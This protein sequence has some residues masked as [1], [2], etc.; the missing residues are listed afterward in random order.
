M[1]RAFRLVR[2]RH[3]PEARTESASRG[4]GAMLGGAPLGPLAQLAEQWTFNPLV[5][6]S[7]PTRSTRI[8]PRSGTS[9]LGRSAF[10]A[11]LKGACAGVP[12]GR[13][14]PAGKARAPVAALVLAAGPLSAVAG[15]G[16]AASPPASGAAACPP[17]AGCIVRNDASGTPPT[18]RPVRDG[19]TLSRAD[20]SAPMKPTSRRVWGHRGG[21]DGR[22]ITGEGYGRS[23][24]GWRRRAGRIPG[25]VRVRGRL[26]AR[27]RVWHWAVGRSQSFWSSAFAKV[28]AA[29]R[30]TLTKATSCSRPGE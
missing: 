30:S 2:P 12:W 27:V 9:G 19:F 10:V 15:V 25:V 14:R 7:S 11:A 6:G 18:C 20:E 24:A 22:G 16:G 8:R 26:G 13:W 4:R 3:R 21:V 5:V 29:V 17:R 23:G 1:P 28:R